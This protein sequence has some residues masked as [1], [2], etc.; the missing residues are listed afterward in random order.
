[1][2]LTLYIDPSQPPGARVSVIEDV[3]RGTLR[4]GMIG[5]LP[6]SA[7]SLD[8]QAGSAWGVGRTVLFGRY[9]IQ[10]PGCDDNPH[11]R[12]IRYVHAMR[13]PGALDASRLGY[14]A[15]RTIAATGHG[16]AAALEVAATRHAAEIAA[17]IARTQ[18]EP[19]TAV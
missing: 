7:L 16:S 2:S 9:I 8:G 18:P 13:F 14:L 5:G 11:A 12:A 10:L 1:M 19:G 17:I 4:P 3:P 6:V 15:R